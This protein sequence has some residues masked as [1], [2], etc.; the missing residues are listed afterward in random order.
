MAKASKRGKDWKPAGNCVL[1]PVPFKLLRAIGRNGEE[2]VKGEE[3]GDYQGAPFD[4]W[5]KGDL[6]V[7]CQ[8]HSAHYQDGGVKRHE[9]WHVARRASTPST[10]RQ[11][12]AVSETRTIASYNNVEIWRVPYRYHQAAANLFSQ[13]F[14]SREA[15]EAAFDQPAAQQSNFATEEN[16]A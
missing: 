13:E 3:F 15:L 1:S 11:H 5:H 10:V 7:V 2:Y 12:Y 6:L 8:K 4:P 16:A 9:S 14:D